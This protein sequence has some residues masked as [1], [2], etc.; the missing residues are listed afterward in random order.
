[1]VSGALDGSWGI[2][3]GTA[4]YTSDG[5]RLGSVV[6]GDAYEL[7][8]ERGWFF[9]HDYQSRLAD[10]D[11]FEEGRLMLRLTKAEVE[12]QGDDEEPPATCAH[13]G[14]TISQDDVVCPHCGVSLVAG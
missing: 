9:I 3:V 4:V 1:M 8:V 14:G 6:D 5:E 13:C 10:V 12:Q 7:I 11:R 2:P